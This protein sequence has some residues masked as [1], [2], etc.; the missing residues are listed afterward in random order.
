MTIITARKNMKLQKLLEEVQK[1]L[2]MQV[3]I[4]V[5]NGVITIDYSEGFA[6]EFVDM[7]PFVSERDIVEKLKA[8]AGRHRIAQDV[9]LKYVNVYYE[10]RKHKLLAKASKHIKRNNVEKAL[11]ALKQKSCLFE[12]DRLR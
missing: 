5:K 1:D 6:K 2:L 11:K 8:L 9:Y 10:N 4:G 3:M 12:K 7:M